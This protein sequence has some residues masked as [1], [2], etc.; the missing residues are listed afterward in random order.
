MP[1]RVACTISTAS[2]TFSR[3]E[4]SM[5]G[6]AMQAG[7]RGEGLHCSMAAAVVWR[8]AAAKCVAA[9]WQPMCPC[10]V[11]CKRWWWWGGREGVAT[12]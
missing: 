8:L 9:V 5:V 11:T 2:E 12:C 1:K 7:W 4:E 10:S 6:H 3:Q